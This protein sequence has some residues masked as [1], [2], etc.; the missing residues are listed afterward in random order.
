MMATLPTRARAQR[1]AVALAVVLLGA[2]FVLWPVPA[3]AHAEL[4]ATTPAGG[5]VLA[6]SPD[7]VLLQ[8]SE[9]VTVGLGE[10]RLLDGSGTAVATESPG[11]QLDDPTTIVVGVPGP[12]ASGVYTVAWQALSADTHPIEGAFAFT[13]G[14]GGPTAAPLVVGGGSGRAAADVVYLVARWSGFAAL[15]LLC[16][17]ALFMAWL[18]PAGARYRRVRRMLWGGWVA[19]VGSTML[20][21]LCYAASARGVGLDAAMDADL[22]RRTLQTKA[23]TVLAARLAVVGLLAPALAVL[24]R[25][26]R[27]GEPRG[28]RLAVA[29]V[30]IADTALAATWSTATHGSVGADAWLAVSMD[31]VHLVAMTVWF[32]GLAMLA[33]ALLPARDVTALRTAVP[34]FSRIA[35]GCV[36]LLVLTGLYAGWRQVR[37]VSAL[38]GTTYGHL[39]LAKAGLV[40]LLV[41]FGAVARSWVRR[42]FSA[43]R[44]DPAAHGAKRGPDAEQIFRFRRQTVAETAVAIAVLGLSSILVA[45]EPAAPA[46]AAGQAASTGR[47]S[48][49]ESAPPTGPVPF[50]AGTVSGSVLLEVQPAR[51]GRAVL[52]LSVLD[53]AG[54]PLDVPEA[55]VALA[56]AEPPVGPMPVDLGSGRLGHYAALVT[57]P[58]PGRWDFAVTVRT[59]DVDQTVV[60]VPVQVGAAS[61]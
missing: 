52:H 61:P 21:L 46:L 31:V 37:S 54:R 15:A 57:L 38:G 18:W 4:V 20:S 22:L 44:V 25:W 60:H 11:R 16:G 8:F 7:Q 39:L 2:G 24:V 23:G 14:D 10:I 58:L 48:P 30:L 13:V 12:L 42:H 51:V 17:A 1:L 41:V 26:A 53:G 32:G 40:V 27:T 5:A 35:L 56:L 43:E 28:R 45:T 33:G 47:S 49:S 59:S 29:G 55:R 19:L 34:A 36:G 3:W 50:R 9:P 6:A